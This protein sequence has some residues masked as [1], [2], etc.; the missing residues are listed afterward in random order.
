[1]RIGIDIDGTLTDNFNLIKELACK[2]FNKCMEDITKW[3]WEFWKVFNTT[4]EEAQKFWDIHEQM[5]YTMPGPHPYAVEAITEL[6][7]KNEIFYI[8][9][10]SENYF[11]ET[12]RWLNKYG[13]FTGNLIMDQDKH[14]ICIDKKI[15]IMIDDSPEY[16]HIAE[17]IPLI[18]FDYPYNRFVNHPSIYKVKSWLEIL[19]VIR[20]VGK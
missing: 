11:H 3:E 20:K 6:S 9:A 8:T 2:Y 19:D 16:V 14:K 5:I 7:Q 10:R 17:H 4:P 1:M 12:E 18:L 13:I 15:S